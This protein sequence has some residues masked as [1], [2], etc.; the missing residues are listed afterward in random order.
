MED[1][2]KANDIVPVPTIS[3]ALI[4]KDEAD[5]I[6]DCLNDYS[7]LVDEIIIYDTGSKDG[8]QDICKKNPKVKLI[9]GEWRNDFGWARNQSFQACTC[10]YIMW[11]DADDKLDQKSLDFFLKLKEGF[12]YNGRH[13]CL[14]N[15]D[16]IVVP[17]RFHFDGK[18]DVYTL[19]RERIFRRSINPTWQDRIHEYVMIEPNSK[20]L[21]LTNNEAY[22]IHNH[23]KPYGDRNIHI[24]QDMLAKDEVF[25]TR[26]MFY[27]ANEL[28]DHHL[29]EDALRW[30]L[31]VIEKEDMWNI[32]KMNAYIR[33]FK[34]KFHAKGD[35]TL[36]CLKYAYMAAACTEVPR[37]DVC[38]CIGEW[39]SSHRRLGIAE[40]WFKLAYGNEAQ[41][42]ENTFLE[43]HSFT[44]TPLMQLAKIYWDTN[45][46]DEAVQSTI[47]ALKFAPNNPAILHN[48]E[49][50]ARAG[51]EKALEFL[52]N[53]REE[54]QK[55][56]TASSTDKK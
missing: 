23:Q 36:E 40:M 10:D 43:T 42:L 19:D 38:D 6:E 26:N 24:F 1:N 31:K 33:I 49:L 37:A 44:T 25:S 55:K 8:T 52:K 7:P 47:D 13:L 18:I 41:G 45:R 30:Y 16:C 48:M 35:R 21:L 5:C 51:S 29:N 2:L 11:V 53:L 39:Y 14:N 4:V 12:D 27:Y 50:F 17:Y 34:L 15:Y 56:A 20:T 54:E 32:D 3:L 22:T 46:K 28:M 9:Q